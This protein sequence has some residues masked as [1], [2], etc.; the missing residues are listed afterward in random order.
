MGGYELH[1]VGPAVHQDK[2]ALSTAQA[3]LGPDYLLSRLKMKA[4]FF[5][6]TPKQSAIGPEL[7]TWGMPNEGA[8]DVS[9]SGPVHT[10]TH[11]L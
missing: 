1:G 3:A 9:H 2:Q 8:G 10:E 6:W 4:Y 5:L 7:P 11:L